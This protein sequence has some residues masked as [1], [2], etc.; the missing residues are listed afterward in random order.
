MEWGPEFSLLASSI[1]FAGRVTISVVPYAHRKISI[2]DV[3]GHYDLIV[4]LHV[5]KSE[6]IRL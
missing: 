1:A 3:K 4:D 2:L 5:K 6:Q